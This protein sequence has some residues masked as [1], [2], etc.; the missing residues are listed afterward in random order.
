MKRLNLQQD[1]IGLNMKDKPVITLIFL[2]SFIVYNLCPLLMQGDCGHVLNHSTQVSETQQHCQHNDNQTIL[3]GKASC[4]MSA[5]G[6]PATVPR[7]NDHYENCCFVELQLIRPSDA[8]HLTQFLSKY[9]VLEVPTA[10]MPEIGKATLCTQPFEEL[11]D[12][13][14]SCQNSPRAPPHSSLQHS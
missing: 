1:Q 3:G 7:Q 14:P 5:N 10:A 8:H 11:H 13:L 4:C 12:Y 9:F 6:S 2:C